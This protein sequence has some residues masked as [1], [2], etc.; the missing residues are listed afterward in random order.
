[1]FGSSREGGGG[2]GGGADREVEPDLCLFVEIDFRGDIRVDI[3]LG[4]WQ[5]KKKTREGERGRETKNS[6]RGKM[7]SRWGCKKK[8]KIL[9]AMQRRKGPHNDEA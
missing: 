4:F 6:C 5:T 8:S 3:G 2:G 7:K 9:F 1:M